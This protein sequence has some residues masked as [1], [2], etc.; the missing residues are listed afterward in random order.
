MSLEKT[1]EVDAIGIDNETG[2]VTLSV[3]DDLE[4]EDEGEHLSLLQEK[5]N[6]YLSFIESGEIYSSYPQAEGR[7][8]EIKIYFKYDFP[9]ICKDFLE[10]SS[11]IISEA[12][13]YLNY[14]I[15]P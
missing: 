13:F 7:N 12:G 5:I 11:K 10:K 8:F 4:W 6:C 2:C 15:M 14:K 9:Q 1:N 3:I